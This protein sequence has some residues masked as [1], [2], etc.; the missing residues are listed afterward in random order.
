MSD[1][2]MDRN[3]E[4]DIKDQGRGD[5]SFS[6]PRSRPF[7]KKKVCRIC[8]GKVKIDYKDAGSLRKFIL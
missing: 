7:F 5:R 3:E 4:R 2:G 6:R 8:T 1:R